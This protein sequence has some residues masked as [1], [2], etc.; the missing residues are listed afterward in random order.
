VEQAQPGHP[1]GFTLGIKAGSQDDEGVKNRGKRGWSRRAKRGKGK[2]AK[3]ESRGGF[4]VEVLMVATIRFFQSHGM[5]P[6]L[7][8]MFNTELRSN[9]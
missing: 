3:G 2:K 7:I 4:L 8:L 1:P 6:A 9:E 5:K